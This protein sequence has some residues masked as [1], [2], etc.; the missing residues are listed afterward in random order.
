MTSLLVWGNEGWL[1]ELV[2]GFFMTIQLAFAAYLL[3]LLIGIVGA[4]ARR[5]GGRVLSVMVGAYC[6]TFRAIPELVLISLIYFGGSIA[7]VAMLRPL[8][9]TGFIQP[10]AFVSG[11]VA[12]GLVQGAYQTEVLRGALQSLPDGQRDA[13]RALG[14]GKLQIFLLVILPQMW[15]LALPG[16]SN[17]WMTVLKGTALVSVIGLED[18]LRAARMGAASTRDPFPFYAAVVV[19]YLLITA[20]STY[21]IQVLERRANRGYQET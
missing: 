20:V 1:D 4:A 19:G 8:G 18:L 10:N 2:F 13:G 16:M 21:A 17:L 6:T 3:G 9:F 11:V 5:S 7:L 14:F 15:R 12:L